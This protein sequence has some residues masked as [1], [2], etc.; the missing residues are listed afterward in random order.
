M[1]EIKLKVTV[2]TYKEVKNIIHN[3][4]GLTKLDIEN[5]IVKMTE[6]YI[7][8]HLNELDDWDFKY[9]FKKIVEDIFDE[10]IKVKNRSARYNFFDS[11]F[12]DAV[13]E[14]IKDVMDEKIKELTNEYLKD[15]F[16]SR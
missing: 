1:E 10:K 11:C 2:D 12:E 7:I 3:E 13:K 4:I 16:K 15:Y 5:I 6:T 8:K 14:K 9:K